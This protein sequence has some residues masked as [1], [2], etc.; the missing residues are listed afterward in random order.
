MSDALGKFDLTE[1]TALITGAAGLLGVQH[2]VALLE[3]GA[4]VVLF[5]QSQWLP[6]AMLTIGSMAF[7]QSAFRTTNSTL[8][9]T[10]VPDELRSRIT[11]LQGI[12]RGLVLFSSLLIGWLIDV[13]SVTISIMVVGL[14][15]LGLGI[16]LLLTLGRVR[17]LE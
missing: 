4:T 7:F 3:S 16:G 2:A 10:L 13:T 1:K 12:G 6:L 17:Q 14:T 5:A 11:S 8:I 15:G 9:Q